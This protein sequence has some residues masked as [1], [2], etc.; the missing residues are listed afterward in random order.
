MECEFECVCVCERV[1]CPS[2]K[3]CECMLVLGWR[4]SK[5]GTWC[6]SKLR[7]RDMILATSMAPVETSRF[8][9]GLRAMND[10]SS[11]GDG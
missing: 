3:V 9:G 7:N 8:P 2:M 11:V 10:Q 5:E 1:V 4:A 6:I